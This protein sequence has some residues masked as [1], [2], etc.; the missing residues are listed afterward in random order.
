MKNVCPQCRTDIYADPKKSKFEN[1]KNFDVEKS[2][3][4][5]KKVKKLRSHNSSVL[6]IFG[7]YKQIL[8]NEISLKDP[9]F[10]LKSSELHDL[11]IAELK[12]QKIL[13]ESKLQRA[14]NLLKNDEIFEQKFS[15]QYAVGCYS[16]GTSGYGGP[17]R[18]GV[19]SFKRTET[20]VDLFVS[21]L[22]VY[23][24]SKQ[25]EGGKLKGCM[26]SYFTQ[27]KQVQNMDNRGFGA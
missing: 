12:G 1:S 20:K 14:Q 24:I 6:T 25:L 2:E 27:M 4:L 18:L 21:L 9:N 16:N 15:S 10:E 5:E 7:K 23:R 26:A 8:K 11:A 13:N 17:P 19:P 22:R 3:I